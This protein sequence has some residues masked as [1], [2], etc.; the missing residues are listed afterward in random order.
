MSDKQSTRWAGAVLVSGLGLSL[1]CQSGNTI[2]GD[3]VS[4]PDWWG[5]ASHCPGAAADYQQV[6]DP[7]RVRRLD[8]KIEA[9]VFAQAQSDLDTIVSSAGTDDLDAITDPMWMSATLEYQGQTWSPIAVRWKG[10]ASLVGAWNNHIGKL[11]IRINF[12]H[13]GD[14][15]PATKGQRFFG[16]DGLTLGN[17]YKDDSLIRD[18][19]AGD[20]L[21]ASGVPAARGSF[22]Q[23]FIDIGNGPFYMGVYTMIEKVEDRMLDTQLGSDSGNLYKPWGDAARWPAI[24]A[25]SVPLVSTS[26]ADI[27]GHFEKQTNKSSDWADVVAAINALHSDRSDAAAWRSRLEAAFNVPSF[28][29][30]LAVNQTMVNW[31]AYGCM[32]H[33]YYVYANPLDQKRFFWLPWDLNEA[34]AARKHDGCVPSSPMLDEIVSGSTSVAKEWP[35]IKYTL[36]DPVYRESYRG[37]LR[38]VLDSGFSAGTLTAQ[39]QADHD[40]VAPYVDGTLATEQGAV[41]DGL[42]TGWYTYQTATLAEFKTSLARTG[43][44]ASTSDGLLVH[45]EKRRQAVEAALG[46]M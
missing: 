3:D 39:M 34:L 18:K 9:D 23:V 41:K 1:A 46:G 37:T 38:A 36:G 35:L 15:D 42:F 5:Y 12:D 33:N 17:G 22:A 4:R 8:L 30:W 27:E 44:G 32:P 13:F 28:L 11:A 43:D 21:R 2:C 25:A 20:I 19:T 45:A 14:D 29:K 10:H 24:A 40:L 31:D 26:Q 6:F 7:A 16:F